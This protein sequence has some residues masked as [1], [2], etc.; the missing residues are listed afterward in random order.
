VAKVPEVSA[1]SETASVIPIPPLPSGTVT[2]AFT[3]IEGSTQRWERAP[4]AMQ[5]A[6]RRHDELVRAAIVAHGGHVFKTVGDAFC[7]AFARPVDA[8]SAMLAAQGALAGEDF[9]AVEGIRVR[10]A[11]HTGVADERDRDYFGPAVNRV[12]R[13]LAIGHGGQILL[14]GVTSDLVQGALPAQATLRDLGAHRLRDLARP[15]QVYQLLAPGLVA[16]FAPLRS[17]DVLPNNL[18]LQVTSLIGRD[19]E[20]A[21]ICRLV[22]EHRLVTLVGSGGVGKTRVSLQ[23]A[24]NLLDGSGDG[25][26]FVELA[27]LTNAE[28][29]VPAVAQAM[30]LKLQSGG[31]SLGSLLGAMKSKRAL[32]VFDNC[33]H[34]VEA[35]ANVI[36]AILRAC[37]NVNVIASSRQGLGIAAEATYRV[38]SLLFPTET[39]CASLL[40]DDA[41]RYPAIAL[42][43]ERARAVVNRFELTNDSAP[44]VGA[45]CRGLDGIPL[46]IELAASRVKI[47]TPKQI[48]DRLHER[49][50]MLTGGSRD[51]LPRQQTLRAMIDWSHALLDER[52]R[53]LFRRLG[54]FVDGFSFEAAVAIGSDGSLDEFAVFDVL[55]SLVDKSLVLAEPRGDAVRYRLLESTRA[56]AREELDRVGER[57]L[58]AA[59][60]LA[61]LRERF[62]EESR[63]YERTGRRDGMQGLF[64]TELEDVRAALDWALGRSEIGYGADLLN[65]IGRNPWSSNGLE[66][67]ALRRCEAYAAGLDSTESARRSRLLKM[68]AG[69]LESRGHNARA[70]EAAREAVALARASGVADALVNALLEYASCCGRVRQFGEA[71]TA[72]AEAEAIGYL[73][74]NV[75]MELL[76]TKCGVSMI[77]GDLDAAVRALEQLRSVQYPRGIAGS[78]TINLAEI[79]HARGNT[80]RAIELLREGLRARSFDGN[81]AYHAKVLQNLAGYLVATDETAAGAQAAREALRKA[82][83]FDPEWS[84]VACAADHLALATALCGDP[85]R[86][87]RLAGYAQVAMARIGYEREYTERLTRDRLDAILD[88]QLPATERERLSAEGAAL[89][90]PDAIALALAE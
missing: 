9:S 77:R 21:E 57:D 48:R 29:I 14:S 17:L 65:A 46:A 10:A 37:P 38:P 25:V 30:A 39:K 20:V 22:R 12:A 40:A 58:V 34:L 79:E 80:A 59:R 68:V 6:V 64:A 72:L 62:V 61:S 24:A 52:E 26:W 86:A 49:F 84:L 16:E 85:E 32:L 1:S 69:T 53:T 71:E 7:A 90:P 27:P 87:C 56:Y 89:A 63:R 70:L 66:S 74:V 18:P 44:I 36:A 8:V 75:V 4:A 45:I 60:H 23:V 41:M 67:E 73:P 31:D 47:F 2:F 88:E 82:A 13:L 11:I 83:T 51:V 76:D 43:V 42:F 50:R 35:A 81:V 15:E 78:T 5:A 33:E 3:D 19:A 55:T 54:I 28:Y